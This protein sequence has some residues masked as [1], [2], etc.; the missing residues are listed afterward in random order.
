[1]NTARDIR[2]RVIKL[3]N[4]FYKDGMDPDEP[5]ESGEMRQSLGLE[6]YCCLGYFDALGIQPIDLSDGETNKS[7]REKVNRI[8]VEGF[9]GECNK[10]NVICITDDGKKD[11]EFWSGTGKESEGE[12]WM[13]ASRQPCLFVSLVR[14]KG[15]QGS[16]SMLCEYIGKINKEKD[17][18]AYYTYG[19]S[20]IVV[21]KSG[22]GYIGGMESILRL[23]K[24]MEIFKMYSVYAVREEALDTCES[25][26]DEMVNCMLSATVKDENKVGAYLKK[27][28]DCLRNYGVPDDF[29]ITPYDTLGNNDCMV[30][31][32]NV[33][34]KGL[35]HEYKMNR[36]LTHTNP[37]Y[38]KSFFNVESQLFCRMG[39]KD[40]G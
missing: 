11:E 39:M 29:Q 19:H 30:E 8:V 9:D 23:Y 34:L 3:A 37:M 1:M 20:D 22:S 38:Q 40:N 15:S 26:N 4:N 6:E 14:L 7:I 12:P 5:E 35:L 32:L 2:V 10:K 27:L 18:I 24:E 21:L 16:E 28:E 33:P 31:I 25:I 13:G 17:M 36:L